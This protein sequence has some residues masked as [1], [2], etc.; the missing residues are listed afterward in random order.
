MSAHLPLNNAQHSRRPV[1]R[2]GCNSGFTLIEILVVFSLV[3]LL[4]GIALPRYLTSIESAKSR[5]Q[6]QN[7]A[8]LRDALDKFR[9]DQGRYPSE[10]N[11]LVKSHYL[12][13]IPADPMNGGSAW[14]LIPF[15]GG[16]E[17]GIFDVAPLA[18]QSAP[19]VEAPEQPLAAK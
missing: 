6:G 2:P 7:L 15:P 13:E 16:G 10:L 19:I 5:A 18:T 14:Q 4:V 11:E 17:S 8:T 9:A 12:R 3:A 1:G